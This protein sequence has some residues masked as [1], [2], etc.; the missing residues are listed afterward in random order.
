MNHRVSTVVQETLLAVD[1]M[2]EGSNESYF[3]RIDTPIFCLSYH[4]FLSSDMNSFG[5]DFVCR[6]STSQGSNNSLHL[7]WRDLFVKL[8]VEDN[9][10]SEEYIE[11]LVFKKKD[12]VSR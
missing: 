12:T 2:G 6:C 5:P 4:I 1:N 10:E 8:S 7:R 9:K 3:S 11:R